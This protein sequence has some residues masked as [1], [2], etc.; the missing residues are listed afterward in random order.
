MKIKQ[1]DRNHRVRFSVK[2]ASPG[3]Q[4]ILIFERRFWYIFWESFFP[5]HYYEINV[6]PF[7]KVGTFNEDSS[8]ILYRGTCG[9]QFETWMP[10][11][12]NIDQRIK[13]IYKEILSEKLE[14]EK[15]YSQ[16]LQG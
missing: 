4:I 13:D 10:G 12:F 7:W 2:R 5:H 11:T 14:T 9:E 8:P 1:L 15:I 6:K 3:V 16:V